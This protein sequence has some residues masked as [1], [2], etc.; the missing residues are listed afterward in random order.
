MVFVYIASHSAVSMLTLHKG[1][2]SQGAFLV[3]KGSNIHYFVKNVP[4]EVM[5]MLRK[6]LRLQFHRS[7]IEHGRR[8]DKGG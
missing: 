2:F 7:C 4:I 1:H 5:S 8:S 3:R 6:M